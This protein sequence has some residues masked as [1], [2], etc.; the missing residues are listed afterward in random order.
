VGQ[1]PGHTGRDHLHRP[2]ER[3]ASCT[4][5]DRLQA[6]CERLGP[7]DIQ[8]FFDRWIITIPTPFTTADRQAGYFWELSMRQVEVSRT[9]V[10]D[11]PRRAR[12]FFES[13]VSDNVGV[14]RPAE[15]AVVFARQVRKTT[16]EPFR[17][18][19]FGPGTE[20]KMDFSYKHS[21]VKQYFIIWSPSARTVVA[22]GR[23]RNGHVAQGDRWGSDGLGRVR[24]ARRSP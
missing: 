18:R 8:A 20:V 4:R 6:I 12:A 24:A 11:D 17:T 5:P 14:G 1:A 3:F 16:R 21:R 23:L 22:Y 13:L 10:F 19:V 9:L 2:G 15:V 7:A